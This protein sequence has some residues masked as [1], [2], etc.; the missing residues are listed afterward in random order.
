MVAFSNCPETRC[1]TLPKDLKR[2][3]F[4]ETPIMSTYLVGFVIGEF[5]FL[6]AYL[7]MEH[8]PQYS[9]QPCLMLVDWSNP[10]NME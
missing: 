2:I 10:D 1:V 9:P 5:D 6:Q 3:E 4:S 8:D 7:T